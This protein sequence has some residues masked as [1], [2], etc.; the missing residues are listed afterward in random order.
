[1]LFPLIRTIIYVLPWW[2]PSPQTV[3]RQFAKVVDRGA[4][5]TADPPHE[6]RG[7]LF[8]GVSVHVCV[9]VVYFS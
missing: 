9:G 6:G 3:V 1:M 7:D 8:A 5:G 4:L 2:S